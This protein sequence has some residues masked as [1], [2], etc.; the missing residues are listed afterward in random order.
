MNIDLSNPLPSLQALV[1]T[2]LMALL[3]ITAGKWVFSRVYVPGLS[4][5]F[6]AA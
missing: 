4:E 6:L 2:G 3:F 5:L 1:T